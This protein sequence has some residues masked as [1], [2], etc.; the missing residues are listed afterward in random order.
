MISEQLVDL[1]RLQFAATAMYHFLFVPLTLGM[2]WLLVIM[3]S[4]YVMTGNVVWKDMTRFWGKLFGINF[5]LGV[6]TGITLE[7]QFGTNWAYYSHYV[8]DIF[9]APLAI[10][11]LMAFFLEST[12]IGL[13]FFGW[14]RL[15]KT[16]HL[17][18]TTLMAVGTNLVGAVDP[19]RQRLDAEPGRRRV[20]L[21]DHAHG[22][23]RLLGR[24][25]QPRRAGQVRAH[26]VG[27]LRDRRDVRAVDFELVPAEGPRRR[28][29]QAQLPRGRRPS[30][31][32]AS[33]QRD[34]ARRRV[35]LHRRRGAA[36]QDG[37]ARSH[38]GDRARTR[39]A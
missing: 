26:G 4:V 11:G 29:R 22:D 20:Q 9:G 28:V 13:F 1:S 12:F 15:S 34:R 27:R 3:E 18:V 2:V 10:E 16:Q 38:V 36:D 35:R 21:P 5:A 24:G 23:D 31:W 39:P 19:D 8:G 30:A 25:V 7:F 14:D 6:T 17:M 37:R 32:P 33:A